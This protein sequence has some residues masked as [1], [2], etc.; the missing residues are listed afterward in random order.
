M[1][2]QNIFTLI[3]SLFSRGSTLLPPPKKICRDCIHFIGDTNE[4]GLF[5][6][7]NIITGEVSYPH[8]SQIRADSEKC[9]IEAIYFEENNAKIITEPYFFIKKYWQPLLSG[10]LI[11]LYIQILTYKSYMDKV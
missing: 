8:A 4:C 11:Y 9:G 10:G 1:K 3:L 2:I 7:I 5:K 6:D